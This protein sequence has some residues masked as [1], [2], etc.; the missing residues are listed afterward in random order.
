MVGPIALAAH[1]LMRL[2]HHT[3]RFGDH[4]DLSR[5]PHDG[6]HLLH[7]NGRGV[8]AEIPAGWTS[9]WW[10]LRGRISLATPGS[11]W[12]LG[13]RDLQ[14]WR[15]GPVR[16]RSLGPQGWLGLA[17][18]AQAWPL[19][20][21]A[22]ADRLFPWQGRIWRDTAGL[23]LKLAR[24][25]PLTATPDAGDQEAWITALSASLLEQQQSLHALLSRCN[26]RTLARRRQTLMRLLRVRHQIHCHPDVR[27]D[28]ECLAKTA[29]YSPCHLIRVYRAVFGETPSEYAARRRE[30]QAWR[31]VSDTALPIC[32]ITGMVGFESQ[33][34]FCRAFKNTFGITASEARR[35]LAER[36]ALAA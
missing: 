21:T 18:S 24:S 36:D 2:I 7:G 31:M 28:L 29:N 12:E 25:A 22:H 19:N 14:I 34:A 30:E 32:E 26:G 9:I 16:C 23:L 27:L 15:E 1:V 11:D 33:S 13:S 17:G 10:P 5:Q 8:Q 3:L 35:Q 20:A 4:L 6:L